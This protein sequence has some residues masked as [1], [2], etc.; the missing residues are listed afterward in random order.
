MTGFINKFKIPTLL[1][2]GII[3]LGIAA[4]VYLTLREQIILSR[5]APDLTPQNIAITNITEDSAV[6]SWQT[7]LAVASFVNF[8]LNSPDEQ[9]VLD[10]RDNNAPKPRLTHY[11]TI[12]NL[13]PKTTYQIKIISGKLASDGGKFQTAP[14]LVNLPATGMINQTGLAPVIGSVTAD[15][16]INEG[17][18]Y[19]SIPGAIIQSAPVKTGGNFLIPLSYTRKNDLAE[20]Q[21]IAGTAAK[22]TIYTD[23][24]AA[25]M[26]FNLKTTSVPLPPIKIGQNIDLTTADE[27]PEPSPVT[28]NPDKYDQNSDG[29][30]NAADYAIFSSCFGKKP[31]DVLPGD[32]SC[33]KT[34][35][36]QDGRI[37]RAD[38]DL[39][40]QKLKD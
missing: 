39:M 1:G 11:A 7:N 29:K 22:L 30:I 31:G 17:V 21:P 38:L 28:Q 2:L 16:P 24:G 27:A 3:F 36:N 9:T 18:V 33:A 4:G 10:D 5:A 14:P 12:K 23:Q 6:I 19:L 32:I 34:D 26:L 20:Y 25:S 13:L 15:A 37:D 8:G 35:I 40:S